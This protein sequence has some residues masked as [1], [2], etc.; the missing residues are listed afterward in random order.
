MASMTIAT[1][2]SL[3]LSRKSKIFLILN[4][5]SAYVVRHSTLYIAA[6]LDLW[7]LVPSLLAEIPRVYPTVMG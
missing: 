6:M 2:V 4:L 7:K 3:S 5:H 1:K